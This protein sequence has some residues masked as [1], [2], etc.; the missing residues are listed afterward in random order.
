[1]D[2]GSLTFYRLRCDRQIPCACC[3][4]RGDAASC[5]Y[6]NSESI[7]CDKRDHHSRD[8]EVQIRLQKLEKMVTSLIPNSEEGSEGLREKS[9]LRRGRCDHDIDNGSASSSRQVPKSSLE[10]HLDMKSQGKGY[11]NATHWTTILENVSD[12]PSG[13]F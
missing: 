9:F 1:M 5:T 2:S 12:L 4:R 7:G 13:T 6:S 3:S 10:G 8:S 11:V